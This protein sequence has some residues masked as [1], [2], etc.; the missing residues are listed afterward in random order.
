MIYQIYFFFVFPHRLIVKSMNNLYFYLEFL[1]MGYNG[2][3]IVYIFSEINKLYLFKPL[4]L[5]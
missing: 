1:I 5:L 2:R 3:N 4:G